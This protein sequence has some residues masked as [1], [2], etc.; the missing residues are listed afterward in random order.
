MSQLR[1][2]KINNVTIILNNVTHLKTYSRKSPNPTE[3]KVSYILTVNFTSG[4]PLDL[5][6]DTEYA[7]DLV[8]RSIEN[9]LGILTIA[10]APPEIP[11]LENTDSE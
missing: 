8:R 2:I 7:A 10:P 3:D 9:A 5:L 1:A 11:K 4:N 6:F